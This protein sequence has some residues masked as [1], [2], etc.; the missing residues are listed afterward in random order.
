[1]KVE[2]WLGGTQEKQFVLGGRGE[3]YLKKTTKDRGRQ[4]TAVNKVPG[5]GSKHVGQTRLAEVNPHV[6]RKGIEENGV[7]MGREISNE[8][9]AVANSRASRLV[10]PPVSSMGTRGSG[11]RDTQGC[12]LCMQRLP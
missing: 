11:G 3:P 5:S 8:P 7:K 2:V 1:M 6:T 4:R 10:S 12:K 9:E